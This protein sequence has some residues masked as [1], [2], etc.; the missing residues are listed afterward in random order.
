MKVAVIGAGIHGLCVARSLAKSGESVTV[1][2]QRNPG[3]RYGSSYGRSRIVR[4]AYPDQFYTEILLKGHGLWHELELESNQRLIYEVGLIL[5]ADQQNEYFLRELEVLE[6]CSVPHKVIEG[7]E[8]RKVHSHMVLHDK[9]VA[10]MSTSAGWADVET[11]LPALQRISENFGA[12]F[13]NQRITSISNLVQSGFDRVV[14]CAG[15]WVTKFFE[16]P[17]EVHLQTYAYM[18]QE[19]SGP[20]WIEGFGDQMYGFPSEPGSEYFKIGYHTPGP[21]IDPDSPDREPQK[22]ALEAIAETAKRRFDLDYPEIVETGCCLY[23][24]DPDEDFKIAWASEH[25]LVVSPCSGHGFKFGPWVG[26]FVLKILKGQDD[27]SQ[28][29]RFGF[30]R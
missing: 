20:V 12:Q 5:V 2:E 10:L 26:D 8:I 17:L 6:N 14:V 9:E 28:W 30:T 4:Q 25:I 21:I 1:F 27:L 16:I 29:P 15:A 11:V 22:I 18:Q 19:M 23:T 7:K 13:V 3:N 24:T